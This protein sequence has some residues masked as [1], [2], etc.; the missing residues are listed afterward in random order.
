MLDIS[1]LILQCAINVAP[2]TMMAIIK[3]ESRGNHLA[4]G[5]NK[6][7]RLQSQPKN[8]DQAA[9]WATYL[10]KNNYNFDVGLA[11]INIKN[12]HKYGYKASDA[13]DP[14]TN[15]K[16]ASDILSKNYRG[17]LNTSSSSHEALQKAISA[18]NTGNYQSGF[19][20]GYVQK[21]YAN[22]NG[23][24]INS[25]GNIPTIIS[26]GSTTKSVVKVV[27]ASKGTKLASNQR[28][29][30]MVYARQVNSAANFY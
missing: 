28:R 14:C 13:L 5:I 2:S 4:L 8:A 29:S 26:D 20:N 9:Q 23:K 15:L 3:T 16:M 27:P 12:I 19:K 11:Q 7:Y 21:V 18:Y 30:T 24:P 6:G 25:S 17:A 22:A 1:A 10:E